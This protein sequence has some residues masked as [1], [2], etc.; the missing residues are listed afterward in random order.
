MISDACSVD[1]FRALLGE[2]E[3]QRAF[4]VATIVNTHGSTYRHASARL[5]IRDDGTWAGNISGGCLE[6]EV[7]DVG[8]RVMK[9]EISETVIYDLTADDEAIWGW[10]LGCNGSIEVL[11]EPTESGTELAEVFA[12]ASAAST[13]VVLATAVSLHASWRHAFIDRAGSASADV[14]DEVVAAA[15]RVL[16]SGRSQRRVVGVG[17]ETDVF[18]EVVRPPRRL[19]ICGAGHDAV[20]LVRQARQL[21]WQPV[22]V[23]D[24]SIY[25][26]KERFPEA[27]EFV[28]TSPAA[29][30]GTVGIR[31]RTGVVIMSHNFLRDV[32]YLRSFIGTEVDYVGTLGPSRRLERLLAH[33]AK[34]GVEPSPK[35]LA[36]I[37]GPAGLDIGAEGPEEIAWSITAE[38]LAVERG[39]DGGPLS[40]SVTASPRC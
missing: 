14:P 38:I 23:D 35:D 10:G 25:L 34:D 3:A 26:T 40:G 27:V 33:L 17:T 1:F 39:R 2:I 32:D 12:R 21:N 8:R 22:V 6:G 18:F 15:R 13:S 7:I 9:S 5:L 28:H 24:R 16:A 20:P 36:K 4:A 31:E 19:V 30:A 37:H 11:V 29:V